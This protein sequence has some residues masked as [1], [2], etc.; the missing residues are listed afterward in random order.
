MILNK[1][2][3]ESMEYERF[4]VPDNWNCKLFSDNME[5]IVNCPHCGK[6]FRFGDS[7]TSMEIHN[8]F[9]LGYAVCE[10]CYHNEMT[11]ERTYKNILHRCLRSQNNE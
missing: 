11:R 6:E 10:E 4:T 5:E 9:G 2:N 7:Y 1:W 8:T 3:Y